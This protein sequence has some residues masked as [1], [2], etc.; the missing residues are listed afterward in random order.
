VAQRFLASPDELDDLDLCA[1]A[2]W[3]RVPEG[4]LDDVAVEFDGDP[5]GVQLQLMQKIQDRRALRGC[6]GFSVDHDV[7]THVL[8]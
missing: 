7:D 8:G 3:G 5:R 1:C 2:Q 4:L 6:A